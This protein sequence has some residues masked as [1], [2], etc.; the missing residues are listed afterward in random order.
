M[1][2]GNKYKQPD[3]DYGF[4]PIDTGKGGSGIDTG[5]GRKKKKT[6]PGDSEAT[7]YDDSK[8]P[9]RDATEVRGE[10]SGAYDGLDTE[11]LTKGSRNWNMFGG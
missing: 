7:P 9:A 1:A 10:E 11:E 4:T 2:F 3:M 8:V 6:E 5:K